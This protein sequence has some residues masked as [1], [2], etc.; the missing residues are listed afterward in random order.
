MAV[1]V[2]PHGAP[3][4]PAGLPADQTTVRRSNLS[5]VLRYLNTRGPASRAAIAA[6]TGLNKTTVSSL[7][8]ELQARG[9]VVETGLR[10]AGAVGRPG[11]VIS[12][13]GATV[14]ALGLEINVDY[15]AT[16]GLDLTGRTLID[17][18]VGFDAMGSDVDRSLERLAGAASE[19]LVDL[20]SA[21]LRVMGITVAVPGLVNVETGTVL[22]AP[23]LGW[24]DVP[25]AQRLAGVAATLPVSVDNDANLAALA[26]FT[27]GV[28]AGTQDLV[29]LTG[30]VGV[31]GGVISGGRLLR[32][33]DGFA[34]EVGHIPVDPNGD[35]CGCGRTGCW[36]TKV[37]LA[38]LVRMAAPDHAYG[39]PGS[40]P[41]RV[42]AERLAEIERRQAA[43]D[44]RVEQALREIA[45]WLGIGGA[46]LVNLL[47][48][49]VIVLG[50][51][52][53][54]FRGQLI[55]EAQA[56][57]D[58]LAVA[59]PDARCLFVASE[60]DFRAAAHGA[61]H[62]A[63]ERVLAD[64]TMVATLATKSPTTWRRR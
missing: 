62:V 27:V 12:L 21:G 4:Q 17:R 13:D 41:V 22:Y 55:A 63:V 28:A 2:E 3:A 54:R 20:A 23:N 29:Y 45:R 39:R 16:H 42:P 9:L 34:G 33:G 24:R 37:G 43:G 50:G 59:G 56:E 15:I 6:E 14:G 57:L 51:Y 35:Q 31:G 44:R 60:L 11:R 5:L 19:A 40:D 47:N 10:Q 58:R 25:V 64:P 18:R 52:F 38:A 30:E 53:A 48:P 46:I 32:G 7:I 36:E 1:Q 26:E 8:S 49:R 61:A